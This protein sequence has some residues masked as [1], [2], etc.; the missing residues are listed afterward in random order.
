ML[1]FGSISARR[2]SRKVQLH[3]MSQQRLSLVFS[4]LLLLLLHFAFPEGRLFATGTQVQ[5]LRP[6]IS[7]SDFILVALLSLPVLL[8]LL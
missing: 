2:K 3:D 4:L 8:F 6:P 5:R 1:R 7:I